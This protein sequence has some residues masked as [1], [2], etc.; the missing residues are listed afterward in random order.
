MNPS[1]AKHPAESRVEMREIV[2]PNDANNRG[3]IFG[4]RVL[5][6]MDIA[7]AMASQRH[8]RCPVVTAAM[9]HVEFLS[10]IPVGHQVILLASVNF[11]ARSSMEVGVKVLSEDPLT[12]VMHHTS[13]AYLTMVC[14]DE[15]GRPIAA[16]PLEPEVV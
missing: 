13:S 2:F 12:G 3:T 9:D 11:V 7:C 6:L 1:E 8:C 16:P 14:L 5:Q 10:G 15:E 4:G